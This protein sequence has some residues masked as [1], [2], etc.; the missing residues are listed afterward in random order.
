MS[1]VDRRVRRVAFLLGGACTAALTPVLPVASLI[2]KAAGIHGSAGGLQGIV[3]A[4]SSITTPLLV[5]SASVAVLAV[6]AGGGALM[7]G[8][9]RA[10]GI[11]GGAVGGLILVGAA[12][13]IV[14]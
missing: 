13:G 3:S 1:T 11:I 6:I 9:R 8:H 10:M 14:A 12:T 4:I 7:M 5:V 2:K